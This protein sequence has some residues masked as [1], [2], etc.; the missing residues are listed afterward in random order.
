[1]R[2][3]CVVAALAMVIGGAGAAHGERTQKGNLILRLDG[4]LSPL[5]L[6]RHH[7]A[8]VTVHLEAGL[9]TDD[10]S[11]LPRVT[12]IELG[13]PAKGVVSTRGLPVCPPRRLRDAKPP[14]ALAACRGALVGRG[15]LKALVRVPKQDPFEIETRLLAF[16]GRVDGGRG[17]ILHAYAADPP[18]VVVLPFQLRQGSGRFGLALVVKLS[19]ALGPWPRLES[20]EMTLARRYAYR[21]RARSYLSASCPIPERQT[22]GF[23]SLAHAGMTLA[24]G[25]QI[26]TAITRGCR[27]RR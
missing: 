2:A 12:R 3:I 20:F 17:V 15:R 18:T 5:R 6:P 25:R 4:G 24:G 13:L 9:H 21:G 7:P 23:F 11:L 22:A 14:E 26:G 10:G 19:P 16:N 8:P 1:M 27:A